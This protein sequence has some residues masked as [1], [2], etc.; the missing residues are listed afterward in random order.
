MDYL[1][2]DMLNIP[3]ILGHPLR[4][5]DIGYVPVS[6]NKFK[7]YYQS[8]DIAFVL[9]GDSEKAITKIDGKKYERTIP[10]MSICMPGHYYEQLAPENREVFY[11]SYDTSATVFFEKIGINLSDFM[12]DIQTNKRISH[13][14]RDILELA[15][16]VHERGI[17]DRID[18]F[19]YDLI[20]E[21]AITC[22][23]RSENVGRCEELVRKAA[24][25]MEIN[26][27]KNLSISGL[28]AKYNISERTFTRYWKRLFPVPP[29]SYLLNLRIKEAQRLLEETNLSV[30]E[31]TAKLNF[32]D[33]LYFSRMFK[34]K[35][36][37]PPLAYRRYI[38]QNVTKA[39][40]RV[41]WRWRR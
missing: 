2:I 3:R 19:C 21:A 20:M 27:R 22:N 23:T 41:A 13:L 10:C 26:Y 30:G 32:N 40:S 38:Q 8:I 11:I 35:T 1:Y 24:S 6:R 14:I 39:S 31:V 4:I 17:I 29:L 28:A 5:R 9:S 7:G 33:A 16:K 36:G 18:V 12:K 34:K 25:F 37:M 15:G